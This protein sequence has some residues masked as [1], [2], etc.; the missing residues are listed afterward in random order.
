MCLSQGTR[1]LKVFMVK[2]GSEKL[3][4]M[5]CEG[6]G[7][8]IVDLCGRSPSLYTIYQLQSDYIFQSGPLLLPLPARRMQSES[9]S[10]TVW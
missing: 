7:L 4:V 10:S 2:S 8:S 9:F 3:L 1:Y 5:K 6:K